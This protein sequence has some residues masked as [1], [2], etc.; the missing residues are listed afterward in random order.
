MFTVLVPW[1][2]SSRTATRCWG[3][4]P[5]PMVSQP[6]SARAARVARIRLTGASLAEKRFAS[7]LWSPASRMGRAGPNP[8]QGDGVEVNRNGPK[9]QISAPLRR[10]APMERVVESVSPEALSGRTTGGNH[11]R[12]RG[13]QALALHALADQ[14]AGAA[15]SFRLL[16]GLFLRRLL[17]MATELHL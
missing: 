6:A 8:T 14:L 1:V 3:A 12:L 11:A 2:S 17:V 4:D 7:T 15:D 5:R 13:Q 10:G 9:T 16:T